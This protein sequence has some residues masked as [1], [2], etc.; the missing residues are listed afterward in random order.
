MICDRS[1]NCV[2][3]LPGE[4]RAVLEDGYRGD[5]RYAKP[6][7][8]LELVDRHEA[9]LETARIQTGFDEKKIGAAFDQRLCLFVIMIA[10]LGETGGAGDVDVLGSR[11]DGARH[12]PGFPWSGILVRRL[13]R[14]LGRRAIQ[15][16]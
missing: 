11:P 16:V 14:D 12:E 5:Y 3:R 10:K 1:V 13:A 6:E 4:H 7:I 15:F 2:D 8:V 9:C